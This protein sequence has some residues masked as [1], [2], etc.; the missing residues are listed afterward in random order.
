MIDSKAELIRRF[1]VARARR[2]WAA[3]RELL[4]AEVVW[5][6]SGEEDY[7]GDHRGRD[8]VAE[9]LERLVEITQGT[10][11]LEPSEFIATAEHVATNVRWRAQRDGTQVEGNDLA[12]YRIAEDEIVEAWFFM[13]GYDPVALT[14][15]FSFAARG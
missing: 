7:A 13:D 3:A 15:V 8:Q 1:Y 10:F 4:A 9:L 11:M 12:V 2:D 5:H 6:E 14:Q